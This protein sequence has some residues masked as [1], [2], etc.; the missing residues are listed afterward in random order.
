MTFAFIFSP[1]S[2]FDIIIIIACIREDI[3]ERF[4][5]FVLSTVDNI[6]R[7][8]KWH[9]PWKKRIILWDVSWIHK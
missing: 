4:E 1:Q 7:R 8:L 9:L 2:S 6:P 3:S 5:K